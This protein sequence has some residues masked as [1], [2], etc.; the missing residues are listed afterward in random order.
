M[1]IN[2][3]DN[4]GDDDNSEDDGNDDYEEHNRH[5]CDDEYDWPL[6]PASR[7]GP[8]HFWRAGTDPLAHPDDGDDDDGDDGEDDGGDNDCDDEDDDWQP[9]WGQVHLRPAWSKRHISVVREAARIS[10]FLCE[11][12]FYYST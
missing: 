8:D 5:N 6:P 9:G 2:N 11:W 12:V 3:D 4:G 1:I 7:Y 10:R